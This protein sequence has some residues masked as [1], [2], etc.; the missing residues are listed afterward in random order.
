M[1]N[2]GLNWEIKSIAVSEVSVDELAK[3]HAK[4]DMELKSP[5]SVNPLDDLIN[6]LYNDEFEDESPFIKLTGEEILQL[7]E[8]AIAW[9]DDDYPDFEYVGYNLTAVKDAILEGADIE[10]EVLWVPKVE[11]VPGICEDLVFE[12]GL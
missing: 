3:E 6:E 2:N 4:K 8:K 7:I 10:A 9:I 11:E 12:Y 5:Y 1:K